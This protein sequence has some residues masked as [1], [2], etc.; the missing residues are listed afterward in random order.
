[1]GYFLEDKEFTKQKRD[2]AIT[3]NQERA[4]LS[5]KEKAEK[6]QE[7]EKYAMNEMM[8]VRNLIIKIMHI[9]IRSV[10]NLNYREGARY[11]ILLV[12]KLHKTYSPF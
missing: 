5:A 3:R 10:F 4:E 1:M 7:R 2:E 12:F 11:F 9:N 6:K 8:R